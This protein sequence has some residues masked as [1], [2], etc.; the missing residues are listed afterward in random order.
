MSNASSRLQKQIENSD[1]DNHGED[2]DGNNP[3]KAPGHGMLHTRGATPIPMAS[4]M[5][6]NGTHRG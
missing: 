6:Q 3:G 5:V 2:N 4:L 1:A